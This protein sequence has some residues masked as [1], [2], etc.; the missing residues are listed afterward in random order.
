M[1]IEDPQTWRELLARIISDLPERQRIAKALDINP[2]TL[3][4]WATGKSTPRP[5][6]L[7]MLINALPQYRKQLAEL[8]AIEHPHFSID[9]NAGADISPEI[10]SSFYAQ[11]LNT[12]SSSP[13]LL[14]GSAVRTLILTQI[15]GHFD[16]HRQGL[17][18][19]ISQC[20]PPSHDKKVRS[21]RITEMRGMPVW[22]HY[23]EHQ[24]QFFGAESQS[25][26]ALLSGHPTVVQSREELLHLFPTHTTEIV[27]SA[28]AFPILL[29]DHAAGCL[30]LLSV[31]A[32]YF[33]QSLLDLA[34][35]YT[36][37]LVLAIEREQFYP[38]ADI[39]LG[40]MPPLA[41]Q[42]GIIASF[43]QRVTKR[44][45]QATRHQQSLTRLQAEDI[46]WQEL[47]EELLQYQIN[48]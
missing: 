7:H 31:Q 37:L 14:R 9:L 16:P 29:S 15:L 35:Q 24:T 19:I 33:K 36:E 8:I 25:G 12:H 10:P 17:L 23:I 4:R 39:E 41:Q 43:Q 46:T 32:N 6:N 26:H 40:I 21:L 1:N 44:M 20:V 38:L 18:A 47:E 34:Q 28:A 3:S 30:T 5:E 2:I 13:L 11:A 42:Q 48:L 27:E 45:I 22:G